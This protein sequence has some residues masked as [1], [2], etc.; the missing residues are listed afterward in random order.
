MDLSR[1]TAILAVLM[2]VTTAAADRKWETGT[3]VDIMTKRSPWVGA[4]S[5]GAE[6]FQ[7]SSTK[8]AGAEVPLYV[9][10]TKDR[11]LVLEDTTGIY[12]QLE[13]GITVGHPVTVALSKKTAYIRLPDGHEYRLRVVKNEPR[14]TNIPSR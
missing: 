8:S 1:C 14:P 5:S 6:P 13:L 9:I 12:R 10:E 7:R 4:P 2:V 3:L 11:R